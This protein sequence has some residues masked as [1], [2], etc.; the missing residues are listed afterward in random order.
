MAEPETD[1]P[2][3]LTDEDNRFIHEMALTIYSTA[4]GNV[5]PTVHNEN[6]ALEW[7]RRAYIKAKKATAKCQ[8]SKKSVKTQSKQ[9]SSAT[10]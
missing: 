1:E 9:E 6:L 5:I 3:V 2:V 7:T 8:S 10:Q 4:W